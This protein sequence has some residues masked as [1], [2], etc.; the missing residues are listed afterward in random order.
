MHLQ[1][2]LKERGISNLFPVQYMSFKP[3]ISGKDAVV[4]ARTGTGKTLAFSLPIV[5]N[6]LS[7]SKPQ[8]HGRG[9]LL[10]VLAPTRE[11]VSQIVSDFE[12]LCKKDLSI[13]G[14]YGGVPLGPQC[15]A[16]R[17]GVDVVV[18]TPG[19]VI[20]LLE[21]TV[22]VLSSIRYVVLDE[23]DRMLDMGFSQNVDSIL[24]GLYGDDGK[25]KPQTLLFS[26]TLPAWVSSVSKTY[27]SENVEHICL[28]QDQETKT[29]SNVTH[30]ALPCPYAERASTI[31]DVIRTYCPKKKS[32]CIVFCERKKDADDLAS[33][34]SM[35]ADCH[36][37]HGGIP[38]DK[39]ELIL[40]KFREGKYRTL[41]T[42]NV[43]ARGLDIQ[44]VDLVI[45]CHPPRDVEDYI[46]RS[47]RTGRA[48]RS[49][50]SV[51][52]Y[53]PQERGKLSEIERKAEIEFR[54]IGPPSLQDVLDSWI[55][56][57]TESFL[58]VPKSTWSEFIPTARSVVRLFRSEKVKT[59][60]E[61]TDAVEDADGSLTLKK[62]DSTDATSVKPMLRVLCCALA[63]L[64]GKDGL[65]E[66]R[67]L[68]NSRP[69]MTTYRLD[70]A[71]AADRKGAAY[72]ALR[73]QVPETIL[74]QLK[75][76]SFI[77]GRQGFVFDIPSQL[78]SK[79]VSSWDNSNSQTKLTV[80]RELPELE[81]ETMNNRNN[82]HGNPNGCSRGFG[83]NRGR[84]WGPRN[85][86][87]SNGL[88]FKRSF[89]SSD[90]HLAPEK[91][92]RPES[93]SVFRGQCGRGIGRGARTVFAE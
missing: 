16:L 38:Q 85:T 62:V 45:Q 28:I 60:D 81:E 79:L 87:G 77:K 21:K 68:L 15:R 90:N 31:A 23:V 57:T 40:Q 12:S 46:H 25:N 10:L 80:L 5:M 70:L 78:N 76:L 34:G 93:G 71:H 13:V 30:L 74:E 41:I 48:T 3:I 47:G 54:R 65:V 44:N 43:A 6:I 51:V 32:R 58:A 82:W 42:T 22:L 36:V 37:F 9:P 69:G 14:I 7:G 26:A 17:T 4:L 83:G 63:Q 64:C 49:G 72:N 55:T 66:S 53:S 67:S 19:R 2:R 11:L 1:E 50:T 88:H 73:Q 59:E 86:N 29:S 20:D 35:S 8:N 33:H 18:G 89:T 84:G 92:F 27:L 24:N 39:R 52:F 56:E 61:M 75:S 91:R